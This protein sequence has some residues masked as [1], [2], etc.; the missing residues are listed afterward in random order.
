MSVGCMSLG[1]E[2]KFKCSIVSFGSSFSEMT[3]Y[4]QKIETKFRTNY[5]KINKLI[6]MK[7][8]S[9]RMQAVIALAMDFYRVSN[10]LFFNVYFFVPFL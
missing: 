2:T 8:K 4:W 1:T 6:K 10:Y 7:K 9:R 3:K 5:A